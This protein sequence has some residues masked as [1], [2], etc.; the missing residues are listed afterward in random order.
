MRA[1]LVAVPAALLVLATV[2]C[3][4]K[5]APA[6]GAKGGAAPVKAADAPAGVVVGVND[7]RGGFAAVRA[8]HGSVGA[9]RFWVV[10]LASA[11]RR[12]FKGR[13]TAIS[14]GSPLATPIFGR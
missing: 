14:W 12:P 7:F 6:G 11:S 2:G 1:R 5:D 4:E 9:S 13:K 10:G 8:T 3:G